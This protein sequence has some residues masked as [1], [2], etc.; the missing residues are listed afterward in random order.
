MIQGMPIS[1]V[2]PCA[3]VGKDSFS[4]AGSAVDGG[5]SFFTCLFV[6]VSAEPFLFTVCPPAVDELAVDEPT[7]VSSTSFDLPLAA[8]AMREAL[9]VSVSGDFFSLSGIGTVF[10]RGDF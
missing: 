6:I 2:A 3:E 4:G 7:L 8:L 1:S 10:V 5:A 9:D